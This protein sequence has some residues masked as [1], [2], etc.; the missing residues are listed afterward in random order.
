MVKE[1]KIQS[2]HDDAEKRVTTRVYRTGENG[3]AKRRM[4]RGAWDKHDWRKDDIFYCPWLPF[5]TTEKEGEIKG[6]VAFIVVNGK[7]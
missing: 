3:T 2:N 4:R 7:K 6:R 1:T 5:T